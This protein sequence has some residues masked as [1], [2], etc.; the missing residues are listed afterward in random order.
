MKRRA[1]HPPRP[2]LMD[3]F[4]SYSAQDPIADVRQN[5]F[6]KGFFNLRIFAR[7]PRVT[8]LETT[9]TG[10]ARCAF[11]VGLEFGDRPCADSAHEASLR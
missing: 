10:P 11:S 6:G 7:E 9:G 4:L 8:M 3:A 5:L 1:R 2:F